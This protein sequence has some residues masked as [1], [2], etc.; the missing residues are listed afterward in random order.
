MKLTT[1][2]K[3]EVFK[4]AQGLVIEGMNFKMTNTP[5]PS[6]LQQTNIKPR[7]IQAVR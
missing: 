5:L 2:P 4:E 7:I 1:D 6:E 3:Y